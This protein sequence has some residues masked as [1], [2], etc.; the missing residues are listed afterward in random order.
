MGSAETYRA[1]ASCRITQSPS[2]PGEGIAN[3]TSAGAPT[4][5]SPD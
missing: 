2:S 5:A 3:G 4:A 1:I